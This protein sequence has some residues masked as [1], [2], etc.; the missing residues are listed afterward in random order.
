ML[1]TP[2]SSWLSLY[3]FLLSALFLLG[4][5][6]LTAINS[7]FRAIDKKSWE[8][9]L[10]LLGNRFFYKRVHTYF[11][12]ENVYEG[13]FFAITCTQ[14]ITRFFYAS[15]T[16]LFLLSSSIAHETT[17]DGTQSPLFAYT[18]FFLLLVG[19]L[20]IYFAVGDYIPRIFGTRYP[21]TALRLFAPIASFFLLLSFPM[22]YLFLKLT[23]SISR[24]IYFDPLHEPD[25]QAK[26]EII[27]IIKKTKLSQEL[28]EAEKKL[29]ASLLSFCGHLTR[30]VMI[31]RVDVCALESTT[32][33]R[34]AAKLLEEEGYSRVP[35]Y[36]GG[37]D[38]IVGIIMYRDILNK[39]VEYEQKG[40][41]P[42]ILEAPVSS[43]QKPPFY[44]PET[45]KISDLLQDFRNKQTHMAIVVDE[46]GGTEGIITIE[47][48]LEDI[49]G[50]IADEYDTEE[51]L[52]I[53][54]TDGSWIVDPRMSLLDS[55][56]QL[57]ISI[58][59]DGDY[60]TIGG[61]I[62]HCA[63]EIP[64]KGFKVQS[65]EF[66]VEVLDSNERS[67]EKVRIRPLPTSPKN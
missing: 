31:P 57:G 38:N 49:V 66:E 50:E 3:L 62:V 26:Q 28:G 53:P 27:E 46:Y 32:P 59:Q 22:I 34:Q 20:L 64:Q 13:L 52:F 47:D 25:T 60:D 56:E 58:P 9:Q 21:E 19:T 18:E 30:E 23:Q 35:V 2:V 41:D 14:S 51:D 10:S 24:T 17:A 55:E 15:S 7:T 4:I 43:I 54:Q 29:L 40:N 44:T 39:Y 45:K 1:I 8:K 67:V 63:G 61:Y 33:I 65:D 42:S 16:L 48:I 6:L 5:A 36:E 12:P 37:V 11:F